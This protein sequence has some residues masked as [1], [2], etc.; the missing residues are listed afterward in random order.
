MQL[1][2]KKQD[3]KTDQTVYGLLFRSLFSVCLFGNFLILFFVQFYF[4]RLHCVCECVWLLFDLSFPLLLLVLQPATA[5]AAFSFLFYCLL[6]SL[7]VIGFCL[8]QGY[9]APFLVSFVLS[10]SNSA[11]VRTTTFGLVSQRN[12]WN[13]WSRIHER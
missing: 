1:F 7:F 6:S 12:S 10:H 3:E 2:A 11:R 9:S 13:Q 5:P 8:S 4:L